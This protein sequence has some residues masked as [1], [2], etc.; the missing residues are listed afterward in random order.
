MIVFW[1]CLVIHWLT[2]GSSARAERSLA[3]SVM[4]SRRQT[5]C[6]LGDV[7]SGML[8]KLE[9]KEDPPTAAS[10]SA[11]KAGGVE[12]HSRNRSIPDSITALP[13]LPYGVTR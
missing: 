4:S 11:L 3:Q 8:E 10:D 6:Q 7:P 12:Y 13:P 5:V 2:F 1:D 9:S